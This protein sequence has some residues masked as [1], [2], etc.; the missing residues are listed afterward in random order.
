MKFGLINNQ[1]LIFSSVLI[2]ILME[3]MK[4]IFLSLFNYIFDSIRQILEE[5]VYHAAGRV[6]NHHNLTAIEPLI[7]STII[8]CPIVGHHLDNCFNHGY[9]LWTSSDSHIKKDCCSSIILFNCLSP[10]IKYNYEQNIY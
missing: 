3:S 2:L 1:Q 10:I 4:F 6:I 5:I 9:N 8:S 7:T